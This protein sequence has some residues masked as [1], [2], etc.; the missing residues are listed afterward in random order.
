[1]ALGNVASM[2]PRVRVGSYPHPDWSP[3]R[4]T[5]VPYRVKLQFESRDGEAL[6]DA[7]EAVQQQI[8]GLLTQLP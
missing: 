7:V 8:P 2:H 5:G 6:E 4:D 1:M 3:N